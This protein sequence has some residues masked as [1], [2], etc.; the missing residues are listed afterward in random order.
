[1]KRWVI[2]E[3]RPWIM[4]RFIQEIQEKAQAEGQEYL[5]PD[6]LYYIAGEDEEKRKVTENNFRNN[7]NEFEKITGIQV[8]KFN[9]MSFEDQ[10]EKYYNDG[11][12]IFMDLNLTGGNAQY[13]NERNNV[14]YAREK[15]QD[16][17]RKNKK[18]KQIWL[19]TTGASLDAG[20]LHSEFPDN[21]VEVINFEDGKAYLDLSKS[22]GI[23]EDEV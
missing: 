16:C 15:Q 4:T 2:V 18:E 1:M 23:L 11:Y 13:F 17:R 5:A 14:Q 6:I 21:V 9:D 7:V 12:M 10:M 22:W 3:D 19:Y 8:Q 20:F